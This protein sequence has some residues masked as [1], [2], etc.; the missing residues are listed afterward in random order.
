MGTYFHDQ[1]VKKHKKDKIVALSFTNFVSFY[2]SSVP[3]KL[4]IFE[5][6]FAILLIKVLI[7]NRKG[8]FY[9]YEKWKG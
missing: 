4:R 9:L 5:I 1:N 2:N 3:G 8:A 7:D 6:F